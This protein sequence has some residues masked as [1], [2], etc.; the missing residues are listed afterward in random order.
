MGAFLTAV[1]VCTGWNRG[2][3]RG[4]G[5]PPGYRREGPHRVRY[6]RR[7]PRLCRVRL[8]SLRS[9]RRRQYRMD[10]SRD[11]CA[12]CPRHRHAR[13]VCLPS[14]SGST[15]PILDLRLF[16]NRNFLLTNLLLS[17]VFFSFA[18]INYLLPF[19]LKYVRNYDTSAAGIVM[20]SLSFAMMGAGILSGTSS[21]GRAPVHFAWSPVSR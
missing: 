13:M 5:H 4:T 8:P 17:L 10:L 9:L 19:Y 6:N 1:C 18:G 2:A 12:C 14:S 3:A 20:T 16:R 21:T 15:N 11:P 7:R